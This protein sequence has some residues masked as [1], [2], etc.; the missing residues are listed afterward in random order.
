MQRRKF[1]KFLGLGTAAAVGGAVT[2]ATLVAT[3]EKSDAVK[4]IEEAGGKV[5]LK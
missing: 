3:S 5:E 2:V 4:K 1:F